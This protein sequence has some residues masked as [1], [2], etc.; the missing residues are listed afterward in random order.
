[1]IE[2][3]TVQFTHNEA[4][5]RAHLDLSAVATMDVERHHVS[6]RIT[7]GTERFLLFL[8]T[9]GIMWSAAD[10]AATETSASDGSDADDGD[11]GSSSSASQGVGTLVKLL[12]EGDAVLIHHRPRFWTTPP[13]E[14]K[15]FV[16]SKIGASNKNC[17]VL[18]DAFSISC[19]CLDGFVKR[20][21]WKFQVTSKMAS[22][23]TPKTSV[24]AMS[25][26]PITKIAPFFFP[27]SAT[28]V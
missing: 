23:T 25:T 20:G 16:L 11:S 1:M 27:K 4:R 3:D 24:N 6:S 26:I 19:T 17:G 12:S 15:P 28:S 10:A 9:T 2:L 7:R 8:V 14:N 13:C 22:S 18:F 5:G 21:E